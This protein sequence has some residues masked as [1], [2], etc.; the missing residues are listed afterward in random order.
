[1]DQVVHIDRTHIKWPLVVIICA[2]LKV[3]VVRSLVHI[4][5]THILWGKV[6]SKLG[7]KIE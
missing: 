6:F 1:L 4:D 2:M 3:I 7:L 5:R